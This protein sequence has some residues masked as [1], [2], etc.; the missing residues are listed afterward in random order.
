[1]GTKQK[2][3]DYFSTTYK[4]NISDNDNLFLLGAVDSMGIMTLIQHLEEHFKIAIDPEDI[5]AENFESLNTI[6][7][8]IVSKKT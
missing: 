4:E 2:L 7:T 8:L 3:R 5:S 1:M 6:E